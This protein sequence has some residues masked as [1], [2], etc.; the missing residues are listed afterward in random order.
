[1]A[2]LAENDTHAGRTM[3]TVDVGLGNGATVG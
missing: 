1:M 3:V 2:E